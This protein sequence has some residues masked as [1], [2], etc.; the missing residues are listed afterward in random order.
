[1]DNNNLIELEKFLKDNKEFSIQIDIKTN[2]ILIQHMKCFDHL[3]D[4]N[5]DDEKE[6]LVLFR[7]SV[8]KD[9]H[10]YEDYKEITLDECIS[11]F[12][13]DFEKNKNET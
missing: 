13:K 10:F 1:M 5:Q 8:F 2:N 7:L 9:N 11:K 6:N 12:L 3:F 4:D